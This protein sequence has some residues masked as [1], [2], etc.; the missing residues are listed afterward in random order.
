MNLSGARWR[1]AL[2]F[3]ISPILAQTREDAMKLPL[4]SIVTTGPLR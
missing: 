4:A 2:R 1:G 3:Y